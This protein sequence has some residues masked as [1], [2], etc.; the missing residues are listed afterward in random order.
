MTE[1][2]QGVW[3]AS[4]TPFNADMSIDRGALCAHV[5]WLLENGCDGVAL[6]G[7]TGE[8]NSLGVNERLSL[9]EEMEG[10]W[11]AD[12][13]MIGVGTTAIPD[14]VALIHAA[15]DHEFPN[16]LL[17]PPFYYKGVSDDGLYQTLAEVMRRMGTSA[18]RI[19]LYDFPAMVGFAFST[20]VIARMNDAFTHTVVGMKDSSGDFARM[21]D[22]L[23]RVPG[24]AVYA[25]TEALLLDILKED[26]AGCISATCN[27]TAPGAAKVWAAWRS[28]DMAAAES[29]QA[30][31]TAQRE[32]LQKWSL[33]PAVKAVLRRAFPDRVGRVIR[34][35]LLNL[36]DLDRERLFQALD[37]IAFTV[38]DA[39][40]P[41]A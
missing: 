30:A 27:V 33:V 25:G 3:A 41:A 24:F 40:S 21:K 31:L 8:A 28:G 11:P 9:I 32:V 14:T 22:V 10:R 26:G 7:T 16:V 1:A 18:P 19:H 36:S 6:L 12:R 5:D 2:R 29:A 34:P 4:I 20:G 39:E 38:P 13:I 23:A 35:P 15:V 17:L 37:E